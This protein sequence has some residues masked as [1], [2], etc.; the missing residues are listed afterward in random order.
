MVKI[1]KLLSIFSGKQKQTKR[2]TV[3]EYQQELLSNQ[4]RE[5]FKKLVEKGLS[6]PIVLL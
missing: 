4:G 1:M 2:K 5:Q 6:V 3:E